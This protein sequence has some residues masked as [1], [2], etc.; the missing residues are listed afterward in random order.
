ME[1]IEQLWKKFK[2]HPELI[3]HSLN[4]KGFSGVRFKELCPYKLQ[5]QL[6]CCALQ[7]GNI[8]VRL[9]CYSTRIMYVG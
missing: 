6:G 3:E 2:Q 8:K 7:L 9:C 4:F 5:L 1:V